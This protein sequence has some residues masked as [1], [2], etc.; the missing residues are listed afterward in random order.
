MK[1]QKNSSFKKIAAGLAQPAKGLLVGVA[2]A[3]T[4]IT[5][6]CATTP[7]NAPHGKNVFLGQTWIGE[8]H[9]PIEASKDSWE[10]A[11]WQLQNRYGRPDYTGDR[12][13]CRQDQDD[14][15]LICVDKKTRL[16]WRCY[17]RDGGNG[18]RLCRPL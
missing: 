17:K 11:Q 15:S 1:K 5:S 9:N 12:Y 2:L 10:D 6:G 13:S 4:V 16:H 3:T 8:F 14:D 18:E 7:T